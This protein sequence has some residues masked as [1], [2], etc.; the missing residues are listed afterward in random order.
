MELYA[1]LL[2][3]ALGWFWFDSLKVRE[4]AVHAAREACAA[5]GL[6]FLDDTVGI[7]GLKLARDSAGHIQLQRA[8][9]FEYSDTGNNRLK[10][11]VV[12]LGQRVS[13]LNVGL[14]PALPL[15]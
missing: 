14:R 3:T 5:E 12:M 2:L 7:S 10:G 13:L 6:L 15:H 11:S 9:D 4:A 1:V 8:Y